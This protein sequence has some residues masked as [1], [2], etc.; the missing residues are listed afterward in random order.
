MTS[1]AQVG[2]APASATARESWNHANSPEMLQAAQRKEADRLAAGDRAKVAS[3][4]E[5]A[6][7]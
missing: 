6:E 3:R 4:P 7:S 5:D 1:S 2:T